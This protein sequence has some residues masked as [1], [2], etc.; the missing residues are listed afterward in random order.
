MNA[1]RLQKTSGS[2]VTK[3]F[4]ALNKARSERKQELDIPAF[5]PKKQFVAEKANKTKRVEKEKSTSRNVPYNVEKKRSFPPRSSAEKPKTLSSMR[6]SAGKPSTAT[7][8]S[9]PKDSAR[10]SARKTM[11]AKVTCFNC[12]KI[13]HY[14][15]DCPEPKSKETVKM[16]EVMQMMED[17]FYIADQSENSTDE[18]DQSGDESEVL[19]MEDG[20]EVHC[21]DDS[22]EGAVVG[23]DA[24][25]EN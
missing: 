1:H 12:H 13:G 7:S 8:S 11:A 20:T 18:S 14:A 16:I 5:L 2:T 15:N 23:C 19:V 10:D 21:Y 3:E 9:K 24:I 6:A 4:I 25:S 17:Q 22:D